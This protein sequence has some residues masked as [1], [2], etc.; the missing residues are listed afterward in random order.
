M[1]NVETD[2]SLKSTVKDLVQEAL[3]SEMQRF[4]D[5]AGSEQANPD[6]AKDV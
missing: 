2:E 1:T 4:Q 6:E 3:S 5:A